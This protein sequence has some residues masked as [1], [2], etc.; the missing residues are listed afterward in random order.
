M[1]HVLRGHVI[2]TLERLDSLET[3][4]GKLA[5]DFGLPAIKALGYGSKDAFIQ[6]KLYLPKE[7]PLSQGKSLGSRKGKGSML[8]F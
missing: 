7:L 5:T 6:E 8:E 4:L 2:D 1:W 3:K